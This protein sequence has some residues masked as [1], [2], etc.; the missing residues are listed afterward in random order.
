VYVPLA[1]T[2]MI[3]CNPAPVPLAATYSRCNL[4]TLTWQH[5]AVQDEGGSLQGLGD[6]LA[7][8]HAQ[9]R[10]RAQLGG[11]EWGNRDTA[12]VSDLLYK[13]ATCRDFHLQVLCLGRHPAWYLWHKS[14]SATSQVMSR[15]Y[16]VQ[17]HLERVC[18]Y[19]M[20]ITAWC[21][22]IRQYLCNCCKLPLALLGLGCLHSDTPGTGH[23]TCATLCCCAGA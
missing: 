18:M 16:A 8:K 2:S 7:A 9:E 22:V 23:L 19:S 5:A 12:G 17:L 20:H 4:H 10:R 11:G 3:P 1:N 21:E 6:H 13:C 14:N 15:H